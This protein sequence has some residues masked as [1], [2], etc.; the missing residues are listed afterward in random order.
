MPN[1]SST[2]ITIRSCL[3][4][5]SKINL[6]VHNPLF[7]QSLLYDSIGCPGQ[8]QWKSSLLP[9]K[10]QLPH[11]NC[12]TTVKGCKQK[13]HD[14]IEKFCGQRRAGEKLC[15]RWRQQEKHD[16]WR[17]FG[18]RLFAG[19][20]LFVM[21]KLDSELIFGSRFWIWKHEMYWAFINVIT[22][23]KLQQTLPK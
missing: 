11:Q 8:K 14:R 1:K 5:W 7:P 19:F 12:I 21:L 3:P 2:Y 16:S 20:I 23:I 6:I 10:R 4:C 22:I 17:N 9:T 15:N 18:W 13:K